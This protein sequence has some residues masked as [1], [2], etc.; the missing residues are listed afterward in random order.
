MNPEPKP[1]AERTP[2]QFDFDV[3]VVGAGPAGSAAAYHAA[4]AGLRT[5]L[6]DK[7]AFPRD[8][9]CGDGL[10]PR[11]LR[12]MAA[13]GLTAADLPGA[14]P[15][16]RGLK[17]YGF[18]GQVTAPWPKGAFPQ[19]GAAVARTALDDAL[20]QQ[21]VAAGAKFQVA[22]VAGVAADA[23][24]V[25]VTCAAQAFRT[26]WLI[27]ADGVRSPVGKQLG[28]KWHREQVFGT[29]ARSYCTS[30]R[31]DEPWIF[32]HLELRDDDGT[33]LP[34][35]G[36][37]FPLGDGLVNLGAGTL[38]TSDAPARMN[39]KKLLRAYWSQVQAEWQLG[40]P[41]QVTSALL[42]MGGA[43]SNIAGHRWALIGDAAACVNPLNGEGI[44]YGMATGRLV[45]DLITAGS[46]DLTHAWPGLLRREYGAAFSLARRLGR[47]LTK[48]KLMQRMG[49][50]GLASP[51]AQPLMGHAA[52]LMGNLVSDSD[53]DV[54][55]RVWRLAGRIS[56]AADRRKPW[57]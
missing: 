38:S 12:E 35:Y 43:V 47:L 3:L 41:Q 33:A 2:N 39:T 18:G 44:D 27:V 15:T 51:V 4:A 45:V 52:R 32:S 6:V 57:A 7:Q 9:T 26:R 14:S 5:L 31:A 50:L 36:W 28:R 46:N 40:E 24:G 21:A 20:R 1:A 30:P 29:A 13:M 10:T 56:L 34:G 49:P 19:A 17:L 16:T 11:A 25:T 42:P 54:V 37:I 48:P 53:R 55:S 22:E 23:A 8:K